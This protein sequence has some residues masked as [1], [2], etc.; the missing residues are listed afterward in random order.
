MQEG[1][2]HFYFSTNMIAVKSREKLLRKNRRHQRPKSNYSG[3]WKGL[4]WLIAVFRVYMTNNASHVTRH[5]VHKCHFCFVQFW[6]LIWWYRRDRCFNRVNFFLVVSIG[7]KKTKKI[8]QNRQTQKNPLI[9]KNKLLNRF[10]A[11]KLRGFP[12]WHQEIQKKKVSLPKIQKSAFSTV[13]IYSL[14]SF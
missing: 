9:F 7:Q 13:T 12:A 3:L 6:I 14:G 10:V 2:S 4:S 8:R 1:I 5:P 11:W